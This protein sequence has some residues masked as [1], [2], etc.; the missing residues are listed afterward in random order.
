MRSIFLG[1][2]VLF[3]APLACD[4]EE[5]RE[6]VD[7]MVIEEVHPAVQMCRDMGNCNACVECANV[8][9]CTAQRVACTTSPS[10]SALLNCH[11]A[12]TLDET[13]CIVDCNNQ[14]SEGR[15]PME[16]WLSCIICDVCDVHCA[17]E[18]C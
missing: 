6:D 18:S 5:I 3:A 7:A 11:N 8:N 2:L 17:N 16:A 12:C 9:P 10:C 14:Y 1:C 15:A 13:N 4:R